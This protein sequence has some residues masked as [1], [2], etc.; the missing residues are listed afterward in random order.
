MNDMALDFLT[1]LQ[2]NFSHA[3]TARSLYHLISCKLC[4]GG[5][6]KGQYQMPDRSPVR[7]TASFRKLR[8]FKVPV[9]RGWGTRL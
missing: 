9:K 7:P 3:S 1:A 2:Q 4:T 8:D 6:H 5:I